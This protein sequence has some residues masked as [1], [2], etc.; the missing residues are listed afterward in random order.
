MLGLP[1][2]YMHVGWPAQNTKKIKKGVALYAQKAVN[3]I[4]LLWWV[5]CWPLDLGTKIQK[6]LRKG[7]PYMAKRL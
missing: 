7:L 1:Y 6:K 5:G 3:Y 2:R 4:E